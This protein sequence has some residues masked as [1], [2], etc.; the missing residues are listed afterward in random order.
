[1]SIRRV[2][3]YSAT[4]QTPVDPSTYSAIVVTF[5]QAGE[6]IVSKNKSALTL[7][8][9]S[10]TVNLDQSE[11][12][13]FDPTKNALMQVRCYKSQY[14]APGSEIWAIRVDPALNEDILS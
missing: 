6:T 12:K 2:C 3:S 7:G 14:D 4:I 11:T 13:L 5:A 1:M 10:I 8:A 9:N